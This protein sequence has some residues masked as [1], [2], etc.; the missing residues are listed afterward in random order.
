MPD[1][2]P[3]SDAGNE[4][5]G[6]SDPG[7][8]PM[9]LSW[10]MWGG[11]A[12]ATFV[13]VWYLRGR[14]SSATPTVSDQSS[15]AGAGVADDTAASADGS[16]AATLL[17]AM[18]DLAISNAAILQK[19]SIPVVSPKP[20]AGT[21]GAGNP[22]AKITSSV[23]TLGSSRVTG[24]T[25]TSHVTNAPKAPA[26]PTPAVIAN[27]I[28]SATKIAA[29]PAISNPVVQARTTVGIVSYPTSTGLRAGGIQL[30]LPSFISGLVPKAQAA[31]PAP[32]KTGGGGSAP[33]GFTP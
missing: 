21:A 16:T 15:G 18:Q 19:L 23:A 32:I 26:P 11:V 27:L 29:K 9:G 10:L 14:S 3:A 17:K 30:A 12:V 20:P 7:K 22:V 2:P 25:S 4:P 28:A 1:A 24:G 5:A 13:A 6:R 31:A 33:A 8:G